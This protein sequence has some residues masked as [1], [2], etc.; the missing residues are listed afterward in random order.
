MMKQLYDTTVIS[1]QVN[2]MVRNAVYKNGILIS[3]DMNLTNHIGH[4]IRKNINFIILNKTSWM[5]RVIG[6]IRQ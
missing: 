2:T 4:F 6:E 5:T 3:Y 1:N